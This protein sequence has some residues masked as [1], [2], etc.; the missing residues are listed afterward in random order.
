[1][2]SKRRLIIGSGVAIALVVLNVAVYFPDESS[3]QSSV[4][5]VSNQKLDS[6]K[7]SSLLYQLASYDTQPVKGNL[8][9]A[10]NPPVVRS[11]PKPIAN[12]TR[13]TSNLNQ[14]PKRDISSEIEILA[15]SE[16]KSGVSA[17][18]KLKGNTMII[19][20]GDVIENNYRVTEI[21]PESIELIEQDN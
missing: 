21:T 8:F 1:M 20:V 3:N 7:L 4:T 10:A 6:N 18:V 16:H 19:K 17:F 15:I 12:K 9:Q 14:E 2:S 5:T 11:K 13:V